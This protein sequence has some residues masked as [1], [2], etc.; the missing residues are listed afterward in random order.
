MGYNDTRR[1]RFPSGILP[2]SG[3]QEAQCLLLLVASIFF[4]GG[5]GYD[6]M[7]MGPEGSKPKEQHQLF[8]HHTMNIA[9][10]GSHHLETHWTYHLEG[11]LQ[12]TSYPRDTEPSPRCGLLRVRRPSSAPRA[13]QPMDPQFVGMYSTPGS[14]FS[15]V[16]VS[17]PLASGMPPFKPSGMAKLINPFVRRATRPGTRNPS[18]RQTLV[19]RLRPQEADGLTNKGPGTS[20]VRQPRPGG[21]HTPE[22]SP[23]ASQERAKTVF[24]ARHL[25]KR[26]GRQRKGSEKPEEA[27]KA[28][29]AANKWHPESPRSG[30]WIPSSRKSRVKRPWPWE[31]EE[32]TNKGPGISPARH[33]RPGSSHTPERSPTAPQERAKTSLGTRHPSKR[34]GRQQKKLRQQPTNGSQRATGPGALNPSTGVPQPRDPGHGKQGSPSQGGEGWG[35]ESAHR[36]LPVVPSPTGHSARLLSRSPVCWSPI[37]VQDGGSALR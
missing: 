1:H 32:R 37:G 26:R 6:S 7:S 14:S 31:A 13:S 23:T 8:H 30:A 18:S 36:N 28:T 27:E 17:S 34:R 2:G 3:V 9:K 20:P 4:Q 21:S 15:V 35:W 22:R 11:Q 29:P 5:A 16:V 12:S 33:P 25:S 10:K 19:K 24:R